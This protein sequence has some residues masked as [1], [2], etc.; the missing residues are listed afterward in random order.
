MVP[1]LHKESND[2]NTIFLSKSLFYTVEECGIPV[3]KMQLKH[4][5]R[6]HI[7][8]I[9]IIYHKLY[10]WACPLKVKYN[11]GTNRDG[12]TFFKGQLRFTIQFQKLVFASV[13]SKNTRLVVNL[14]GQVKEC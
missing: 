1:Y 14:C 13:R 5:Y 3:D 2:E 8:Y 7:I 12:N 4:S 10:D 9:I 6:Y 11:N